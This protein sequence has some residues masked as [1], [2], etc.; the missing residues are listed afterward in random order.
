VR[1]EKYACCV[2]SRA[3]TNATPKIPRTVPKHSK[4]IPKSVVMQHIGVGA[5]KIL[6]VRMIFARIPPNLPVKLHQKWPTKKRF[7]CYFGRRWMPF[8]SYFQG[9]CEGFLRFFP[10]FHVFSRIFT[11]SKLFV[12]TPASYTSGAA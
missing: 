1:V 8:C 10:D 12:R 3:L 2:S 4:K 7:L 9:F 6:G 11:K 5:G